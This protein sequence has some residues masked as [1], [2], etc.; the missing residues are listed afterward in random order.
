MTIDPL[1]I[2]QIVQNVMREMK[3]R[4]TLAD[5]GVSAVKPAEVKAAPL[6]GA[7]D[8]AVQILAKVIT[9]DVLIS[10]G[11]AGK[12]VSITSGAIVTP[13]GRDF[14][15]KN[16]VRVSSAISKPTGVSSGA[17]ILIGTSPVI[18]SAATS[19]GWA[20]SAAG[21]EVEAASAAAS[22]LSSSL[23]ATCGGEPSVVACL[24]NRKPEVRAAVITKSTNLMTLTTVMSPHVVCLDSSG[25]SFGDI[26]KL[27]R[28][29]SAASRPR[30]WNEI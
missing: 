1:Y 27:L 20:A 26:L 25:W 28:S 3:L 8:A 5:A 23:V 29:L 11:A 13:S 30:G 6:T 2:D 14:I 24:L 12:T 15:K 21:S 18:Q 17:L 9:E 10:A 19:A 7:G 4:T 22:K 16:G